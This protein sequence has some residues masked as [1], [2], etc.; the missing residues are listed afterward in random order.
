M[1][2]ALAADQRLFS[3]TGVVAACTGFVLI[4]ALQALYGPAIPA[5]RAEHGLGPAAAGLALSAHFVGGLAGVVLFHRAYGRMGNRLLLGVSY[6]AMALGML[7]FVLS[8]SWP[9][10]LTGALVA[11]VGYGGVDYGLNHL[12]A[13]GFGDRSPALLNVLNGFFGVGSVLAPALLGLLG[14]VNHEVVFA[15]FAVLAAVLVFA[16][17]GIKDRSAPEQPVRVRPSR[18]ILTMIAA[19]VV[20][21]VLNIGVESGVGGWEPT[22]LEAVGYPAGVAALATSV[23]WLMMTVGRFLV[24]P[25]ALRWPEAAIVGGCCAGM[26]VCLGLAVVPALSPWAYAGVGLFI[27]PVFPTGLPWLYRSAPGAGGAYVIAASMIGGVVFPPLLGALIGVSTVVSAPVTLFGVN[28][29]C[30]AV[31]WWIR[32]GEAGIP[33]QG[34]TMTG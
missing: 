14:P 6:A 13:L 15:G 3:R 30:L 2:R 28:A 1:T 29:V 24:V 19:F 11:G 17:G 21:Y 31:V 33:H 22:H 23:F 5:L 18:R 26:A 4:G 27:G 16:L 9:L 10:A 20:L 7:V 25:L 32:R 34:G 12:F 8:P